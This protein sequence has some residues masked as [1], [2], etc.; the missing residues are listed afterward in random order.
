M[1][2]K[3]R[4]QKIVD[5]QQRQQQ[6]SGLESIYSSRARTKQKANKKIQ[7]IAEAFDG[8]FWFVYDSV[9]RTIYL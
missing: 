7:K 3:I 4:N 9:P 1:N 2:I 6:Y 8:K 5:Q